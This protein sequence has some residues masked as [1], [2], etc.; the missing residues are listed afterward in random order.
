MKNCRGCGVTL[1]SSNW[2]PSF[3]KRGNR[4]CRDCSDARNKA[5]R[6]HA[7]AYRKRLAKYGPSINKRRPGFVAKTKT[8]EQT[9]LAHAKNRA[10][11]KS[12]PFDL[13]VEDIIIPP[14][15]PVLGI[16]IFKGVGK[17]SDNSPS[18]DR[19][20]PSLGYVR[21]NIAVISK[22]ANQI[23]NNGSLAE[24]IKIAAWLANT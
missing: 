15:C 2:Y 21:G 12:L 5:T 11:R 24:I 9:L 19:I 20:I 17:P 23:K 13:T 14:I 10:K 6:D 4:E 22:R 8:N 3:A 7:A 1:N 18:L 16:P